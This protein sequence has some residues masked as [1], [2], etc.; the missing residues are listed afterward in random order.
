[1]RKFVE[2]ILLSASDQ[3]QTNINQLIIIVFFMKFAVKYIVIFIS[4]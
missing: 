4:W 2:K 1:M 3:R